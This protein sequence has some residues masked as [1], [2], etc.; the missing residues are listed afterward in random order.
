MSLDDA[1]DNIRRYV[2][3]GLPTG[4]FLEAVLSNDLFGAIGRADE[5][6]LHNLQAICRYVYNH[7]PSACWGSP[8]KVDAWLAAKMKERQEAA[9]DPQPT[10]APS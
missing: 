2:D 4:G 10:G 3:D 8:A 6:S 9:A 1:I 5:S 7:V